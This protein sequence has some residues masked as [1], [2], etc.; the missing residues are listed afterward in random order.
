MKAPLPVIDLGL[1][2]YRCLQRVQ[3]RLR[4]AVVAGDLPGALLLLEHAP[5]ITLGSRGGTA[6]LREPERTG[7]PVV[8][9]ERGGAATLHAP[10]QLVSYPVWPIPARDLRRYV[11]N[12]EEVLLLVMS[13]LGLTARREP[14]RP[15]LYFGERKIA[16]VGLRVERWVAS[17]GTALNVDLDLSL[18]DL[19]VSCGE[20]DLRQTSIHEQLGWAP[21]MEQVKQSYVAAFG[22]VFDIDLEKLRTASVRDLS[23]LSQTA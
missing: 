21:P 8:K 14:G 9:S 17:H 1:T 12:L 5:V 15:G 23:V 16:S 13:A 22:E 18:F 10:G 2:G 3:Q 7:L 6:D 4:R 11:L 20:Q 19:V